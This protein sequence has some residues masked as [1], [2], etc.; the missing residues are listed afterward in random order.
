M[1]GTPRRKPT[2]NGP[3]RGSP[4][5][6]TAARPGE[7]TSTGR[8]R[9]RP[10]DV[11]E[12]PAA[13]EDRARGRSSERALSMTWRLLILGVV[14]AALAVTLAQSLRVYF[15]QS[16]EIAA[17]RTRIESSKQEI[18]DLEDQLA[19]W[20]DPAF[21]K[22][23][24]RERLGWVLPGET[25]YR[26]IGADGQPLGGNSTVLSSEHPSGGQWWEN[27]WG[28][29]K[30]ADAPTGDEDPINTETYPAPSPTGTP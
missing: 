9:P 26:V 14:I 25:G 7:R 11:D 18:A 19:R 15:A 17:L 27:L 23:E 28:S 13:S 20:Q 1:A 6:R 16:Q 3:G 4:R 8:V 12:V 22:A 21:V 5:S 10:V 24:A 29:V 2:S 30:V